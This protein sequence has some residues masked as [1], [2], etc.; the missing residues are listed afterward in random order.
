MYLYRDLLKSHIDGNIS[1]S[2][3]SADIKKKLFVEGSI[4]S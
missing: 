3:Y 4:K 1:A 2:F